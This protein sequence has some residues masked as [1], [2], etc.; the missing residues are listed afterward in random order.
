[1]SVGVIMGAALVGVTRPIF[2]QDLTDPE[3]IMVMGI[4]ILGI[5]S[6]IATLM[7][8]SSTDEPKTLNLEKD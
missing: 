7:L 6:G 5:A 3:F 8:M 1:M 2:G 4:Y